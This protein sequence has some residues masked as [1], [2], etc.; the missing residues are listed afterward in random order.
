MNKYKY[1]TGEEKLPSASSQIIQQAKFTNS[2]LSKELKK[3]TKTTE[4][5]INRI[6]D[7]RIAIK[8]QDR[9]DLNMKILMK[10]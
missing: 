5:Q 2:L 3:Q 9:D 10:I 1:L 6:E 8:N 7:W 4:D